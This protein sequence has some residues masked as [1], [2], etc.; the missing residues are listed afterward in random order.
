MR[1]GWFFVC[2]SIAVLFHSYECL[3]IHFFRG[4][5]GQHLLLFWWPFAEISLSF[6]SELKNITKGKGT[7][8]AQWRKDV[9]GELWQFGKFPLMIFVL[10]TIEVPVSWKIKLN[11]WNPGYSFQFI[12]RGQY[13]FFDYHKSWLSFEIPKK[14]F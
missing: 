7:W 11:I 10:K 2:L 4:L 12:W 1:E 5:R 13:K 8:N 6:S 14:P 3:F 9:F